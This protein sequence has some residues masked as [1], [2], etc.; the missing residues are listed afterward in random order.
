MRITNLNGI[1]S[2]FPSWVLGLFLCLSFLIVPVQNASAAESEVQRTAKLV[3]AAKKEEKLVWYTAGA[4][5]DSEKLLA[6]FKEKYP[7]IE[8]DMYRT[9]AE[10]M[11]ARIMTE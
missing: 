1:K 8:T 10:G 3:E 7:F 4:L 11:I 5:E 6:R 9:G 2:I